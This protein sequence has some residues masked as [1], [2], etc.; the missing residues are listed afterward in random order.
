[1]TVAVR[2]ER[3]RGRPRPTA[4]RAGRPAGRPSAGR[5]HQGT[6]L[7]DQTEYRVQTEQAGELIVRLQNSMGAGVGQGLGPGDPVVV[8]WREEA[9]LV[10][11]G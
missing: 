9:N 10:L 4:A 7:G 6:Y 8:R 3:P 1:M 5:I 11:V 2:P